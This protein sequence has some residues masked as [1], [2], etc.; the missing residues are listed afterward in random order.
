AG[1]CMK[2]VVFGLS[3]SS[4]WGNGHATLWRALC[5]ALHRRGHR[6][7][8]YERDAPYYRRH[9]DLAELAGGRLVLYPD[10]D[11]VRH[12]AVREL[13]DADAA[14]V[15]SYCPDALAAAE[16]VHEAP[17]VGAFYDL[18][19]GVTLDRIGRGRDVEYIGPRGLR[20]YDV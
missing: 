7:V 15:T 20:D 4:S 17:G 18:D 19:T 9:R 6:V 12:D 2:L 5:R 8:F 16:L 13:R 3:I 10:W 14:I 1:G 11:A